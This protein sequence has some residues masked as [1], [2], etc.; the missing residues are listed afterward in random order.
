MNKLKAG[1]TLNVT[2]FGGS[3][4]SGTGSTNASKNSWRALTT[5]FLKTLTGG[6][7]EETNAGLGGT[8]SYLGAAR[9]EMSVLSNKPDLL[10]IEFAINDKYSGI[11]AELCKMNLEYMI[12]RLYKQ[13]PNADIVLVLITNEECFGST[14][15]AYNAHKEVADYYNIPIVDLGIELYNKLSGSRTELK[16]VFSD[17]VHPND[18]GYKLYADSMISAL[19]E[20]FVAGTTKAHATPATKLCANGFSSVKNVLAS[21]VSATDWSLKWWGDNKTYEKETSQFRTSNDLKNIYPKYNA[22][23]SVGSSMSYAFTGNSFGFIGTVKEGTTLTFTLDGGT[24]KTIK[25]VSTQTMIEYP[26]F[27]NISKINHT[28]TVTA[29]GDGIYAAIVAFVVMS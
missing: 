28:V 23:N 21:S 20:L 16:K 19:K 26:V 27:E 9:F 1:E 15:A 2:Y 11:S 4:T 13:N 6:K 5:A 29:A 12:N 17:S 24:T 25:G 7:V 14:Y 3:V 22:P 8:G 18:Q 10:F